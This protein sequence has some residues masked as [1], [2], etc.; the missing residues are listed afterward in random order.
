MF[1]KFSCFLV[2]R[3]NILSLLWLG[4]W[5]C[6]AVIYLV[7]MGEFCSGDQVVSELYGSLNVIV[8]VWGRGKKGGGVM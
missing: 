1:A 7:K 4:V 5:E 2:L 3:G 8:C 6:Y